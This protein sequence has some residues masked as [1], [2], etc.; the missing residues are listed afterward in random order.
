M[1][2][3]TLSTIACA[4]RNRTSM[5]TRIAQDELAAETAVARAQP[6]YK[7]SAAALEHRVADLLVRLTLKE[8]AALVAGA[9]NFSTMAVPRLGIPAMRFADGANGVRSTRGDAAAARGVRRAPPRGPAFPQQ[10]FPPVWRCQ[11]HGIPGSPRA[12][13]LRSVARRARS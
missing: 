7:N 1:I 6:L 8:K 12:H 10:R 13:A 5:Q 2:A 9:D 3:L 11:R 4:K